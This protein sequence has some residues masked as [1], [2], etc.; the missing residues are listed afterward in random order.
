MAHDA[1][2]PGPDGTY[3][4]FPR[5]S[6]GS[7]AWADRCPPDYTGTRMPRGVTTIVRGGQ[8]YLIDQTPRDASGAPIDPP[9]LP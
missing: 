8:R 3:P 1:L 4:F 2:D 9:V 6:D 7:P 5:L